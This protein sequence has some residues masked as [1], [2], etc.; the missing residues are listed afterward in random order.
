MKAAGCAAL[1][2][3]LVMLSA[4][5]SF[6]QG[7]E[8]NVTGIRSD[9]AYVRVGFTLSDPL[10]AT[11]YE[12]PTQSPPAALAYTIELWRDRSGWFDQLLSSRTYGFRL[13]YDHLTDSYRILKPGGESIETADHEVLV[14]ILCRQDDVPVAR[15]SD[16]RSG[17]TYYF[18]VTARLTPIDI[19]QLGEVEEWLSGEIRT[20]TRR[21]GILGVPKALVSILAG[22]AGV[23]DRSTVIRS[24]RFRLKGGSGVEIVQ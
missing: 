17:K 15:S 8:L 24:A 18:A 13:E 7:F 10:P 21:G 1:G 4:G 11:D 22:V 20:G 23:G 6:A 9:T 2:F 5:L 16:L 14:R 3:H 19:N 12:G